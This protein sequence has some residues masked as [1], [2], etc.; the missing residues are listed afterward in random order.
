MPDTKEAVYIYKCVYNTC[1]MYHAAVLTADAIKI[2]LDCIA[3]NQ[4]VTMRMMMRMNMRIRRGRIW[5]YDEDDENIVRTSWCCPV[6]SRMTSPRTK[7]LS[8]WWC[9]FQ[10][11]NFHRSG[12]AKIS[13]NLFAKLNLRTKALYAL[14]QCCVVTELILKD[15]KLKASVFCKVGPAYI[16]GK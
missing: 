10:K 7:G 9:S 3:C 2:T 4:L 1:H 8:W 12:S 16:S 14:R 11:F 5:E 15:N 13:W 6:P